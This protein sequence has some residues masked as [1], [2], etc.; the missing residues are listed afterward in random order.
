L[1]SLGLPCKFQRL[2]RLGSV[3]ARHSSSGRQPNFAA[4]NRGRHLH[5]A[6][7][8]S[9]WALARILVMNLFQQLW[10]QQ[11]CLFIKNCPQLWNLFFFTNF[12]HDL[13]PSSRHIVFNFFFHNEA[14]KVLESSDW[15]ISSTP[16]ARWRGGATGIALDLR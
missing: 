9:R 8:P 2:S 10:L 5:S 12:S 16:I 4:L 11:I 14:P 1:A 6:G 3:T 7:R 13:R 15:F